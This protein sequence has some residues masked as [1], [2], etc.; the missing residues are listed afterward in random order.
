LSALAS[1]AKR[2][3]PALTLRDPERSLSAHLRQAQKHL[4]QVRRDAAKHRKAHLEAI[5][6]QARAANQHKKTM[7]LKYLIRAE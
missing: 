2:L 4:K 6:N 3:D 5:L 1:I 7:A